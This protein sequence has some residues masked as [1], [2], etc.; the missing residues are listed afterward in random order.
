MIKKIAVFLI[1][2][3][4]VF[5]AF[6]SDIILDCN[7]LK[8][9]LYE[10][11]GT[12]SLY[13]K[14]Q[15]TGKYVA[16][17]EPGNYSTTSGFYLKTDTS[18]RKL[19][20]SAGI[21][22]QAEENETGAALIY[23]VDKDTT[24]KIQFSPLSS[25]YSAGTDSVKVDVFITNNSPAIRTYAAKAVF[26]TVLGENSG[27]H[28]YTSKQSVIDNEQGFLSMSSDKWI[29]SS[30]GYDTIKFILY[31]ND[32]SV[33]FYTAVSNRDLLLS[34]VWLPTFTE[35]R[36]FDS[37]KTY[38]NSAVA[39]YWRDIELA[40]NAKGNFSFYITTASANKKAA[41]LN[42]LD[43]NAIKKISELYSD[44]DNYYTDSHGTKL[45]IG[46]LTQAQLDPEYIAELLERIHTLEINADG[47]NRDEILK[48][49]AELDAI[50]KKIGRPVN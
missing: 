1:S 34:N 17:I 14:S 26:D 22:I 43:K 33:P 46:V 40:E 48:L 30:D 11:T 15:K 42:H 38:N 50:M 20:R 10:Y 37:V 39:V 28:F 36:L 31:G 47:S 35:G 12:F 41:D 3:F 29:A 16:L 27:K 8:L 5:S 32:I 4:C 24:V 23:E 21:K 19:T 18:F 6:A 2:V 9:V 7:P 45:T 44:S 49:N 13:R 25:G